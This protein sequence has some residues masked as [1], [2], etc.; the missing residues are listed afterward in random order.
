MGLDTGRTGDGAGGHAGQAPCSA[1]VAS[2]DRVTLCKGI[3]GGLVFTGALSLLLRHHLPWPTAAAGAYLA[4]LVVVAFGAGRDKFRVGRW[5]RVASDTLGPLFVVMAL[6]VSLAWLVSF[7]TLSFIS[8]ELHQPSRQAV[9]LIVLSVL[10]WWW[11]GKT[12]VAP[13]ARAALPLAPFKPT[14]DQELDFVLD[15][16]DC[17]ERLTLRESP[18]ELFRMRWHR[19]KTLEQRVRVRQDAKDRLE[20]EKSR[21]FMRPAGSQVRSKS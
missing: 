6:A 7:P 16:L 21:A 15:Q 11:V 20:I 3:G 13:L 9:A 10:A 14:G 4:T 8:D 18:S 5:A 1:P 12:V 19:A 2:L 17:L